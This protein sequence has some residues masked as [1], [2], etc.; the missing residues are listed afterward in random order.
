MMEAGTSGGAALPGQ[1]R[2]T[3]VAWAELVRPGCVGKLCHFSCCSTNTPLSGGDTLGWLLSRRL[4]IC[5]SQ[6]GWLLGLSAA[7]PS[8]RGWANVQVGG[9]GPLGGSSCQHKLGNLL[10]W[11][12]H[13][14][15]GDSTEVSVHR[16]Q[17]SKLTLLRAGPALLGEHLGLLAKQSL[18]HVGAMLARACQATR[19]RR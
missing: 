3:P 11:T 16:E 19:R 14:G 6:L 2:Q 13:Q 12:R 17:R 1:D 18:L 9:G 10:V 4:W 15:A 8:L 7:P 5:A